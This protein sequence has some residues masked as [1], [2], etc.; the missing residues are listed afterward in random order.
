MPK[1]DAS[2]QVRI[3]NLIERRGIRFSIQVLLSIGAVK[4]LFRILHEL[5]DLAVLYFK[6]KIELYVFHPPS[7]TG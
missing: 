3:L 5:V 1:S 4:L 6:L 7:S 2:W